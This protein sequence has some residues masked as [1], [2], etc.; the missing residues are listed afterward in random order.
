MAGTF[1]DIWTASLSGSGIWGCHWKAGRVG[2]E[3]RR[4][5]ADLRS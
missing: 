3:G 2:C 4:T 1:N 5:E